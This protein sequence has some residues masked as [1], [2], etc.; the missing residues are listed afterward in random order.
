MK[1]PET[2]LGVLGHV[3]VAVL[4][5]LVAAGDLLYNHVAYGDAWCAL[6]RCVSVENIKP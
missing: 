1:M 3:I 5:A 6:K 4:I 2:K